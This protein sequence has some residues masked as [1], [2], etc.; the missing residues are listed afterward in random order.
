MLKPALSYE[1]KLGIAALLLGWLYFY[2]A[3]QC[4]YAVQYLDSQGLTVHA[5]KIK[6]N[7]YPRSGIYLHTND[8]VTALIWVRPSK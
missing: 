5:G 7:Y 4:E 6:P 1:K 2:K 8:G 3:S